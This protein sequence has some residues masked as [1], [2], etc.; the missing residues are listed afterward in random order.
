MPKVHY[1]Q[2]AR[3]DNDRCGVKAGES[4]FW[5]KNRPKGRAAGVMRCSKTRPRPS[6]LTMSDYRQAVYGLQE[7]IQDALP[8]I[9]DPD[10]LRSMVTEW[11]AQAR[12]IGDDQR[13][14]LDNFP[15]NLR[16]SDTYA[17]VESR[18]DACDDWANDLESADIPDRDDDE[19]D[20]DWENRFEA[21]KDDIAC[22]EP[23]E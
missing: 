2:K 12:D 5:W 6:Q 13:D 22:L 10:D 7:D 8:G 17:L 20:E 19:S 23:S 1:V 21:A 14:K 15:D 18:A 9:D 4:Y 16:D 3:K 11:A